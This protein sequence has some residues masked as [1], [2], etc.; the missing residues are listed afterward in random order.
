MSLSPDHIDLNHQV[1]LHLF[2]QVAL[3]KQEQ[4]MDLWKTKDLGLY[5]FALNCYH[6]IFTC[7]IAAIK[8]ML[9][10]ITLYII[11]Q[12]PNFT[13][14]QAFCFDCDSQILEIQTIICI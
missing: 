12:L 13:E 11:L 14:I 5:L 2:H 3:D 9:F 7:L 6:K 8:H 10:N 1:A 4:E